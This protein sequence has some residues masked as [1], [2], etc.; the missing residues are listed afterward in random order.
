VSDIYQQ[1]LQQQ[2]FDQELAGARGEGLTE[3]ATRIYGSV[4]AALVA[5]AGGA[6]TTASAAAIAAAESE[7][8]T[9][10]LYDQFASGYAPQGPVMDLDVIIGQSLSVARGPQITTA[11]QIVPNAYMFNG[12][13]EAFTFNQPTNPNQT[14]EPQHPDNYASMVPMAPIS[15]VESLGPGMAYQSSLVGHPCFFF[16]AG[17][18]SQSAR[19]LRKGNIYFTNFAYGLYRACALIRAAGYEPNLHLFFSQGHA[20]A[21][22]TTDGNNTGETETTTADYLTA[23]TGSGKLFQ[24]MLLAASYALGRVWLGPIWVDPLL[25]GG[26]SGPAYTLTGRKNI[27]AAQLAMR[28]SYVRLLPAWSQFVNYG[29]ADLVHPGGQGFRYRAELF[30]AFAQKA[31]IRPPVMLSKAVVGS[32]VELTFD[33]PVRVSTRI[34]DATG[35]PGKKGFELFDSTGASVTINSVANHPTTST[36]IVLTPASVSGLTGPW[37]VRAG[38]HQ[39]TSGTASVSFPRTHI[40]G[41]TDVG[42]AEDGT[43]MENPQP[44]QEI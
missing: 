9:Q 30:K 11:A 21:N 24:T 26:A 2:S 12:G 10:A 18:G 34:V 4:E 40:V 32:T 36:K 7:A 38:L 1:T 23:T 42:T 16:S 41:T 8:Q 37:A 17:M 33:Q 25:T 15:G 14:T 27:A 22:Q 6:A 35:L 5:I 3:W 39:V 44:A 19:Q 20:N 28:S 43:V 29:E 31:T 13:L